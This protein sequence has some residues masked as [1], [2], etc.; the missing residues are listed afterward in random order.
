[1][2]TSANLLVLPG[3]GIGEEVMRQGLRVLETASRIFNFDTSIEEDL[4]HGQ[5]WREYGTLCRSETVKMAK[6]ADGVLVGAV[7]E[8]EDQNTPHSSIPEENDGLMRLRKEL[9]VFAGLR[10][11]RNSPHLY[12]NLPY[13]SEVAKGVDILFLREMCGGVMFSH[14][15]GVEVLSSGLK[16]A[17]DTTLYTTR[18]IERFADSGF[19]LA[20]RRKKKLVSVDKANVMESGV[21]WRETVQTVSGEFPDV[22]LTHMYADNCAYQLAIN[23]NQ[24][25]VIIADNLFGDILSDQVGSLAGSLGMLPSASLPFLPPLGEDCPG[26]IYEPVHGSAPDI[27]G[28]N[29]ANPIGMILS[30]ALFIEYGL[31]GIRESELIRAA[32]EKSLAKGFRTPDLGGRSSPEKVTDSI[33]REMQA[34][35]R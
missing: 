2:K 18:E 21:L 3:D 32:T 20:Q 30:V 29:I 31:G 23:P 34:E 27:Y 9:D 7:G 14:P 17:Y 12:D 5:A 11:V 19:R 24:F 22:Q 16:Q 35:A 13:R 28:K 6:S 26:G 8:I 33:I 1:M 4:I 10:P 25:D 15:R